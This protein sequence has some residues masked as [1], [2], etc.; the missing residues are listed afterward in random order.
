[1]NVIFFL[2]IFSLFLSIIPQIDSSP[3]KLTSDEKKNLSFLAYN[4]GKKKIKYSQVYL[5]D[6][7]KL[8]IRMDCSNT[9]KYVFKKA[10]NIDLPRTSFDQYRA[11]MESGNFNSTPRT[12]EGRIDNDML[13]KKMKSGDILFWINTHDNIPKNWNPPIGHV[14]IYLGK[15]KTG[16]KLMFGAGTFGKGKNTDDGGIDVYIFDPE[17]S[18]GCV[19]NKNNGCIIEGEFFGFGKPPME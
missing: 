6:N 7:E 9:V 2:F 19:K 10:L 14:M 15:S 4:L 1:M 13:T 16:K 17:L 18:L 5:P 11:V 8:S 3:T 12:S